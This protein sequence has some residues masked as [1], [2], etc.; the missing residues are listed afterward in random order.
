[1]SES[2]EVLLSVFS[3]PRGHYKN[4]ALMIT[5]LRY[6]SNMEL[7]L[8]TWLIWVGLI[9]EFIQRALVG[10]IPI[11]GSPW[12]PNWTILNLITKN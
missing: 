7:F 3:S 11:R 5:G 6:A 9:A 4:A 12:S 1:M 8:K 10:E 2:Y